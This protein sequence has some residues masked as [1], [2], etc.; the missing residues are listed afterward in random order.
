MQIFA[1]VAMEPPVSMNAEHVRDEKVKALRSTLP[2]NFND[3]VIGQYTKDAEGKKQG[4]LVINALSNISL[5][6]FNR[7]TRQF[8]K[9][10]LLQPLLPQFFISITQDGR[11][12]LSF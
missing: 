3:V 7:K 4:Y 12:Y 1:L 5:T 8:Q 6:I 9:T 2:I 10:L 11:E